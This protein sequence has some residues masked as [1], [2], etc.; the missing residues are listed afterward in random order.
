MSKTR[1]IVGRK[2]E[3][4]GTGGAF[5][6]DMDLVDPSWLDGYEVGDEMTVAIRLAI[7]DEQKPAEDKAKP[8]EGG[9][10][11]KLVAD[12]REVTLIADDIVAAVFAGQAELVQKAKDDAKGNLTTQQAIADALEAGHLD[13]LHALSGTEGDGKIGKQDDCELCATE[14]EVAAARARAEARAEADE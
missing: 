13:G 4:R 6:K 5:S 14:D 3:I 11:R 8:A 12:A 10:I 9:V 7:I 1:T 2:L